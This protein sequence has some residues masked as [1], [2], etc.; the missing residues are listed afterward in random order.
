MS[1]AAGR[2]RAGLDSCSTN[3]CRQAGPRT[4][5]SERRRRSAC[6]RLVVDARA[7]GNGP[8]CWW[9]RGGRPLAGRRTVRGP[10]RQLGD[11]RW[12]R[13]CRR[14]ARLS[15][16]QIS[17]A[18]AT[19]ASRVMCHAA[20]RDG[21]ILAPRVVVLGNE[22]DDG[23]V[24]GLGSAPR[25]EPLPPSLPARRASACSRD[26][27]GAVPWRRRSCSRRERQATRGA[28]W[29]G[30]LRGGIREPLAY[31][32][33]HRAPTS[34]NACYHRAAETSRDAA[35]PRRRPRTR[36]AAA[37]VPPAPAGDRPLGA[38]QGAACGR[39]GER[40]SVLFRRCANI[41]AVRH[42]RHAEHA[43]HLVAA[44]LPNE[45]R[46]SSTVQRDRRTTWPATESC[47]VDRRVCRPGAGRCT[48]LRS[49]IS[50]S[51]SDSEPTP[52]DSPD[53]RRR[54]NQIGYRVWKRRGRRTGGNRRIYP[55]AVP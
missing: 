10:R 13:R 29:P 47:V 34:G 32:G 33:R 28:G 6:R 30:Y 42:A 43:S 54:S 27:G 38:G 53:F 19:P 16:P 15:R 12:M 55:H 4:I 18:A 24:D 44:K 25:C 20:E 23:R 37:N 5:V 51:T 22:R 2:A 21:A 52:P 31:P 36:D 14:S 48:R 35:A 7:R 45:L 3:G 49:T 11:R 26:P 50:D 41:V 1:S 46:F 39:P 17:Q 8:R 40:W 9:R